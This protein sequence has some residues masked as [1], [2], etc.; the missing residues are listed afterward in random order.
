MLFGNCYTFAISRYLKRG[1]W[2]LF[3]PSAKTWV[4]HT[5]WAAE[6]VERGA[7]VVTFREGWR[8]ITGP[9]KGYLCWQRGRCVW[10]ARIH[11]LQIEEYLPP[12]WVNRLIS[13]YR[14]CRILP[15]HAIAFFGWERADSGEEDGTHQII[16]KTW[17]G[18][19]IER[20]P[21]TTNQAPTSA[22]HPAE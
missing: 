22:H 1:G 14:I 17:P 9:R 11:A 20:D 13:R 12:R 6:G 7:E 19:V 16:E 8:R 18:C 4:I 2:I 10:R 5:Q 3:R 21:R 15:L